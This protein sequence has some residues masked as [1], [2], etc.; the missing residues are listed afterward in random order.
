MFS[1]TCLS[2][3][4]ADDQTMTSFSMEDPEA[5]F[6]FLANSIEDHGELTTPLDIEELNINEIKISEA[7]DNETDQE[8][9]IQ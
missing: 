1:M 2:Q 9:T 4:K 3:L 8:E 7:T 6:L 5:F